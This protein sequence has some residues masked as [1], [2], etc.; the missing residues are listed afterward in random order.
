MQLGQAKANAWRHCS[1]T[2]SVAST[3][4]EEISSLMLRYDP[5]LHWAR[6]LLSPNR[7]AAASALYAWCRRLDQ[8]VDEPGANATDTLSKLT[9]WEA[10]LDELSAGT[11]RDAMD[12][13]LLATLNAYP[14]LS[15]APFEGMLAGM[16]DDVG[17]QGLRYQRFRPEL[18]TYCYRVAGTVGEMLLPV[19][20]LDGDEETAEAAIALGCAVQV[21]LCILS[22]TSFPYFLLP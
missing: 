16:R 13:A 3:A 22:P 4:D 6:R 10:R 18:L 20:G 17:D 11:P 1:A 15:R 19:L 14:S 8:I 9:D 2:A 21:L 7:A 5:L 12:G